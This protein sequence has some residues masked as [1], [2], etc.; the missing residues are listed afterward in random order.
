[1]AWYHT[2]TAADWP[3]STYAD[4]LRPALEEA[5]VRFRF[6]DRGHSVERH[7]RKAR[8]VGTYKAAIE[9]MLRRMDDQSDADSTFYLHRVALK[10]DPSRI[11]TGYRDET[12][13]EA[14]QITTDDLRRDGLDA[15]R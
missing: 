13:D 14:A 10:V 3:S 1:M 4:D 9:N 12:N 7:L 15:V 11:N 2:S 8:H 5:A 6:L